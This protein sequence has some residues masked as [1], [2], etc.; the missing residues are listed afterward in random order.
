MHQHIDQK[1]I[2]GDVIDEQTATIEGYTS[3]FSF[4]RARVGYSGKN[5]KI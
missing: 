2:I 4:S 1:F 3:F 5:N